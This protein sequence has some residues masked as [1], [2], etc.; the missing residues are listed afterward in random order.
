MVGTRNDY[1]RRGVRRGGAGVERGHRAS[2]VS[3]KGKSGLAGQACTFRTFVRD[4]R[5]TLGSALSHLHIAS[6]EFVAD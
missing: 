3:R 5:W 6:F 1:V 2:E 4:A